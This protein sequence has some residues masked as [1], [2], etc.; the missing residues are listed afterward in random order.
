MITLQYKSGS[1][2]HVVH[3]NV[4]SALG[5]LY[6]DERNKVE[7]LEVRKLGKPHGGAL[8]QRSSRPCPGPV[9]LHTRPPP[10]EYH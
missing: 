6:L 7:D 10:A 9:T 3:L 2:Q 1:N 8:A 5:E 4:H